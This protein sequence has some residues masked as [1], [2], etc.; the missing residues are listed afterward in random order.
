MTYERP[1]IARMTGYTPGEQPDGGGV[2]KLNTNEN[3]YPPSDA[4]MRALQTIDGDAL[5]RYPHPDALAFRRAAAEL[6]G[7]EADRIIATNG[8]DELLRLVITTFVE[9]GKPIGITRPSYSLYP[10]LAAIQDAPLAT[11]D[12]HDDWSMPE[13]LAR[14]WNDAGAQLAFIVNP[15]APS[16]TLYGVELLKQ[17]AGAF[18][19]VLVIDEA[20]ADFVDPDL[21]YSSID[22]TKQYDNVVLLRTMSKG[23]SLA[24]LRFGYGIGSKGLIETMT[25]KT[26]DSYPTD[27]IAQALAGAA[28][29]DQ[30]GAAE[31]WQ[32]VRGER[33]RLTA[34]LVTLGFGVSRSQSN[35]VLAT[36]PPAVAGGAKGLYEALKS[37]NILV[38]YFDSERLTDK[39]RIS[40][41]S[42]E[43]NTALL[44][45]LRELM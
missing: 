38:R 34:E 30:P 17:I 32:A 26:K 42:P 33:R 27:A 18:A 1:N 44:K 37:R 11:V 45:A 16:G 3:P 19:G 9:P 25:T 22:L 6:H 40:V 39:L 43:E 28:I 14:Q 2:I 4:V 35:F 10:V 15:H 13:D 5:R 21:N 41:G 23:Y 29:G 31:T 12:L 8:G 36:I 7:V 24:G 20:Y